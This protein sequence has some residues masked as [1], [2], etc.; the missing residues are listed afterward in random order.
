MNSTMNNQIVLDK[1]T[2]IVRNKVL[3]QTYQL[4]SATLLFSSLC[5]YAGM[6][7]NIGRINPWIY[8]GVFIGLVLAIQAKRN[9]GMGVV[10]LFALTG[11]M[12]FALSS[13]MNMLVV[14]MNAGGVVVKA[15]LGTAIIFAG[16]SAY[17][18]K[19]GTN[20]KFLGGYLFCALI[21]GIL[22]SLGMALFGMTG[23]QV[24]ISALFL[25]VFSGYVLY[26]TS[27][28]IHGDQDNYI[29]ATLDLFLDIYNIF[30][31]LLQLILA[32]RD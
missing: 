26:D 5:A 8:F 3:R 17:V 9:S 16:L 24:A 19:T 14:S 28:I 20:F 10:L 23:G 27:A 7:M 30:L 15:L 29:L 12:G 22:A 11:F 4:L 32:S 18:L 13:T 31:Y 21:V 6:V 1:D 25:L 2:L